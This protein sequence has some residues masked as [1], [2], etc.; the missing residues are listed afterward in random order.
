MKKPL[1][2]AVQGR[3][4]TALY[5]F[6][7]ALHSSLLREAVSPNKN[8]HWFLLT[9][10]GMLLLMNKVFWIDV[11]FSY[12]LCKVSQSEVA[13][14]APF[15]SRSSRHAC[16]ASRGEAAAAACRCACFPG[17]LQTACP[18]CSFWSVSSPLQLTRNMFSCLETSSLSRLF[19]QMRVHTLL[20][21]LWSES[22]S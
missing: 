12:M 4:V 13:G 2:V 21:K 16:V 5:L 14:V 3:R 15:G 8:L 20:D 9:F 11:Q 10:L 18:S 17:S 22:F 7:S 1:G 19:S 6:I